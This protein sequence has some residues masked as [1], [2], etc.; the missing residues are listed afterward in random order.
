M[1]GE[2]RLDCRWARIEFLER[3]EHIEAGECLIEYLIGYVVN[4]EQAIVLFEQLLH[5]R[6]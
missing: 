5:L 2:D 1:V 4:C 3:L 6:P